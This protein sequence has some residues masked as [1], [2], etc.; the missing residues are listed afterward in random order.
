[1]NGRLRIIH[2][3]GCLDMGG[4]EKLLVEF[5]KHADRDRFDL[6]FVSLEKRG[7]LADEIEAQGWPVTALDL[8][9]GLHLRLPWRLA[10]LFRHLRANVVHTH[11]DRPL[12]YAGPAAR[13]ISLSR[14]IH[15]KHGRSASNSQRQ[16]FL[17]ALASRCVHRF[18]CVSDDCAH[19]AIEQGVSNKR[20]CTLHNGI[21]TR[22]FAFAGPN[23]T[24]P[25]VLVAR[26][27][28]DKDIT[29]LL[30]AV[31]IVIQHAPDFRLQ[32]AGDGPCG[33]ALR[34]H[35]ERL[36]LQDHIEFLGLVRDVPALLRQARM[37]VLSSISEGVSLTLLEAMA[38][39][40]PVVA[41]RVG[42]TPEVVI[43][44]VTGLLVPARDPSALATSLL[45][46]QHDV[47]RAIELGQAGRQRV[48]RSFDIRQMVAEY[49]HLYLAAPVQSGDSR[50]EAVLLSE[51]S[52]C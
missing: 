12:I 36:G 48:E 9:P 33:G 17:T 14:V 31:A 38:T 19:L 18:V 29:T 43:D 15:T 23:R 39:G 27:C 51:S 30:E 20:V 4:Q 13:L 50:S 6:H 26:L 24:G 41:T 45:K 10:K 11:N 2:V 8:A 16:N 28:A 25:A 40:L 21:D 3:T 7:L 46:L 5:A 52:A 35:A 44:G 34:Q 1:M 37:Y 22:H 49:E 47:A 42:G 32:I